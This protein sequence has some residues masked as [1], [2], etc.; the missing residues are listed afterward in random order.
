MS[1]VVLEDYCCLGVV[2]IQAVKDCIDVL[3]PLRRVVE[4]NAH[5]EMRGRVLVVSE[6]TGKYTF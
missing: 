6:T 5:C 1:D 3:W 4:G 2:S